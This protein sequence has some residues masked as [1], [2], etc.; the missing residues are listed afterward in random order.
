MKGIRRDLLKK[1]EFLLTVNDI[2][3]IIE[4]IRRLFSFLK[5]KSALTR[6]CQEVL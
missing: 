3:V 4:L 1:S 6:K 2:I 5:V